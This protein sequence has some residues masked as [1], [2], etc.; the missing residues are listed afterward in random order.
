MSVNSRVIAATPDHV[1]SVL[2]DGW[3]YPAWVVGAT[4]VREVDRSWPDVGAKIHHS[5]GVW[6]LVINDDTEVLESVAGS[7]VRL[8]ARGWPLG[9]ADVSLDLSPSGAA[10]EVV[11]TELVSSGPGS[12]VPAVVR[13]PALSW[14][15]V[16]SLRR[17]AYIAEGRL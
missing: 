13:E 11:M 17:L 16:E 14:R 4:R 10:T 7:R 5:V 15:N 6:P 3:L 8:R 1:W 2:A 9:E 12:L